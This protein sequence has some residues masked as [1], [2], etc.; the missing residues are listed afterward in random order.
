MLQ[1]AALFIFTYRHTRLV[2]LTSLSHKEP[3]TT[4]VTG[5]DSSSHTSC[6][7]N[8]GYVFSYTVSLHIHPHYTLVKAP[9]VGGDDFLKVAL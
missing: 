7:Y 8:V 2:W 9:G 5:V 4:H 3:K 6:D 1:D